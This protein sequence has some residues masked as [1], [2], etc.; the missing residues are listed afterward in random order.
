VTT[1]LDDLLK[2][3]EAFGRINDASATERSLRMLNITRDTGQFLALLVNVMTARQILEVG[4]SN[5]YSTLWLAMAAARVGGT[6]LTLEC[7][8]H[9]SALARAN[10][11]RSGLMPYIRQ[12]QDDAGHVFSE[13]KGQPFDLLFLDSERS[14]YVGWWPQLRGLLRTGGLLVVDNATS[15]AAELQ[16]FFSIVSG[17]PDFTTSLIPI[18]NGEFLA[19]KLQ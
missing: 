8:E 3:L 5:G 19:T 13:L 10:F 16:P 14:E 9:K 17:D 18:G 4:T 7:S 1:S 15:H 2:E 12:I 6:V 11:E